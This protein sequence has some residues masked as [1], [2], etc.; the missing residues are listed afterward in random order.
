M[1][2]LDNTYESIKPFLPQGELK[3]FL[4]VKEEKNAATLLKELQ[5][6]NHQLIVC[7]ANLS[8]DQI[9]YTK[10]VS[11]NTVEIYTLAVNPKRDYL[12]DFALYTSGSTSQ[13]KLYGFT[14]KQ[15]TDTLGDYKKIYNI[16]EHSLIISTLPF[17]YNFTYIAGYQLASYNGIRYIHF[18]SLPELVQ[19]LGIL[20]KQY[21]NIVLLANPIVMNDLAH[22]VDALQGN[23]IIDSGGA[24]LSRQAIKWYWGNGVNVREG[25]GLTETCS[26]SHFDSEGSDASIGTVGT[27]RHGINTSIIYIN[28][29]P[30]IRMH[31]QN[32][33]GLALNQEGE[34]LSANS[35]PESLMTS[36]IGILDDKKR[37]IVLGRQTDHK[38]NNFWPKDILNLIAPILGTRCALIM[39]PSEDRV[40]I[41]PWENLSQ[42][43]KTKINNILTEVLKIYD[44]DISYFEDKALCHS[45]KLSRQLNCN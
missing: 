20:K 12:W 11:T 37:L 2:V 7:P 10:V 35:P 31:S 1:I 25:Y 6:D 40:I 30:I 33:F 34:P 17:A 22:Y 18:K 36:D 8:L 16:S 44:K 39:T 14:T 21:S 4:K 41:K 13:P 19:R 5:N 24:L 32:C 42:Q 9:K 29:K 43:E 45:F 15:L 26:F 3:L 38:I 23:I 28:N 27:E